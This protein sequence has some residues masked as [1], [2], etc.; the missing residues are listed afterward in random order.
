MEKKTANAAKRFCMMLA[1]TLFIGVCVAAHRL[2]EFGADAYSCMNLGISGFLRMSFGNWQLIMNSA[3][4]LAMFFL[5]RGYIRAGTFVN[6]VAVGYLADF[7]CW[8]VRDIL[9]IPMT[10]P[11]R[12]LALAL[13]SLFAGIGVAFY[14]TADMG[15]APYDSVAVMIQN[16]AKQRISF[17]NARILG[18]ITVVAVGVVF[19][20]ISGGELR[21][22]VGI[23]TI[24]NALLNGPLIQFFRTHL[25]EPLLREG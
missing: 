7:L 11:L 22:I 3:I 16:A 4:L 8:L 15:L 21:L 10:F 9:Q 19:C 12:L 6:L 1:G 5:V 23:G 18:D 14:M 17:Q 2:S 20:L 13:G 25:A 24:C